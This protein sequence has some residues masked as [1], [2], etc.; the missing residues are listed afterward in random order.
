MNKR[1][2]IYR[3]KKTIAANH[4]NRIEREKKKREI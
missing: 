4:Q 2:K 1:K 3:K